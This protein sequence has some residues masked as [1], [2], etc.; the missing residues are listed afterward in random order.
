MSLIKIQCLLVHDNILPLIE[1]VCS[2]RAE[3]CDYD[4][5]WSSLWLTLHFHALPSTCR[6]V[7]NKKSVYLLLQDSQTG[8]LPHDHPAS[9]FPLPRNCIFFVCSKL[10]NF[11]CV[12]TMFTS[13]HSYFWMVAGGEMCICSSDIYQQGL[14]AE[15]NQTNE[16]TQQLATAN[17]GPVPDLFHL[18]APLPPPFWLP[19]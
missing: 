13:M 12:Q 18:P 9:T 15:V 7:W 6:Q 17:Y 4:C 8:R 11:C 2:V 14:N 16:A 1:D 10:H 19:L 3:G 5:P